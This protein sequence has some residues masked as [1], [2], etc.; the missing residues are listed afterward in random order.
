MV[1]QNGNKALKIRSVLYGFTLAAAGRVL[2]DVNAGFQYLWSV[3]TI[4]EEK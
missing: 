3:S 2:M 4:K 1:R